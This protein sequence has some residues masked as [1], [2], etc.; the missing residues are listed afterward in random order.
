MTPNISQTN[1]E[2]FIICNVQTVITNKYKNE[3]KIR[4]FT[5]YLYKI[6]FGRDYRWQKRQPKAKK[7]VI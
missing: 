1:T 3:L 4:Y 6:H 2:V 5:T 7:G